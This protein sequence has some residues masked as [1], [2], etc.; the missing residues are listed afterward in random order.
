M[1]DVPSSS[2]KCQLEAIQFNQPASEASQSQ[3]AAL[4]NFAR[5]ILLPVGSVVCSM[6]DE[7]TF[8]GQTTNPTPQRW[9][10]ADGRNVSGSAYQTLTGHANVPDLRGTFLRGKDNG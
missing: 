7:P 6:L 2:S 5:E 3:V 10:L 1:T 9:I 4:A 8:Q